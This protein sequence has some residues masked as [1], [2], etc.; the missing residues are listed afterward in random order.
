MR[1]PNAP[2]HSRPLG[3][4]QSTPDTG[5][6]SPVA[7]ARIQ[8][9]TVTVALFHVDVVTY[10]FIECNLQK[11]EYILQNESCTVS[12]DS[13]GRRP[14]TR[15]LARWVADVFNVCSWWTGPELSSDSV[16]ITGATTG[17]AGLG[18]HSSVRP[19]RRAIKYPGTGSTRC[20]TVGSTTRATRRSTSSARSWAC[21]CRPG[22]KRSRIHIVRTTLKISDEIV[23]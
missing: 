7:S 3:L 17:R 9:S 6:P 15:T 22:L 10:P 20:S 1:V 4:S 12:R 13:D 11:V 14:L 18:L 16:S 21:L 19:A 2:E 23:R 8:H 5:C